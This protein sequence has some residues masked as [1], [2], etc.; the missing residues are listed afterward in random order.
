MRDAAG[1]I[2]GGAVAPLMAACA[3]DPTRD[4]KFRVTV[5]VA[6]LSVDGQALRSA[7]PG[8]DAA[9][10]LVV[11]TAPGEFAAL[12]T[13]CTHEG[14]PVNPPANG[15]ITCPCHGSQYDLNGTVR[16]GPAQYSLARYLT[17]YD[18]SSGRLMVGAME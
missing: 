6:S 14:C 16:R 8:T 18:R 9:P 13:I 17:S 7:A 12:S 3:A 4:W 15:L 2:A 1:L 5:D 10:M 11:R